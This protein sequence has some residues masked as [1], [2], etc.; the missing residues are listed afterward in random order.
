MGARDMPGKLLRH[1]ALAFLT[2]AVAVLLIHQPVI[3]L[4]NS[5]GL[6]PFS[7]YSWRATS[8]WNVPFVLSLAFWGGIWTIPI[9]WLLDRLPYGWR[10]WVGAVLLGA[11]PPTLTTWFVI[12]PLRHL[13]PSAFA[14][15]GAVSLGPTGARGLGVG[16]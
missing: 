14:A 10:F 5:A 4:L 12:F 9:T 13:S 3:A 8:P 11:V 6:A 15:V 16:A 1:I 7:A 2:G